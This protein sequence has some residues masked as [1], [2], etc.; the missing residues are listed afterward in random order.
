MERFLV[1]LDCTRERGGLAVIDYMIRILKG[2]GL[3]EFVLY[4][5]LPTASPDKLRMEEVRRIER[6]HAVRP[7]L[8][9]YFWSQEDETAMNRCFSEAK[10]AL[11]AN[12][13]PESRISTCFGVESGDLA[14]LILGKAVE[15]KCTTIVVGRRRHGRF[16][17]FLLGSVS[18]AVLK[19]AR[20]MT[21]WV[22][23]D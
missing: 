1:A 16:R 7:D 15:R 19:V 17:Q 4:H 12:G 5:I 14:E 8:D 22:V 2:T 20:G 3:C 11:V 18:S 9:G 21:V 13:F 6:I 10:E 23:E